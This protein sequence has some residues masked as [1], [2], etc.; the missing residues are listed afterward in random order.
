MRAE[1]LL[2]VPAEVSIEA[3]GLVSCAAITAV[4]A[5][6]RAAMAPGQRVVVIGAGAIGLMLVQLLVAEAHDVHVANRSSTGREIALAEGAA[7]GLATDAPEGEGTLDRVFDLVGTATSM[8]LAGRL[9][10][11]R[12]RI[13]VIGEEPEFPEIDSIAL[14]QR[15]IELVEPAMAAGPTPRGRWR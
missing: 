8:G 10:R 11:R 1:N 3:A 5:I 2:A 14:A 9:V 13:V 7:G 12:G 4:H 15:E 6:D